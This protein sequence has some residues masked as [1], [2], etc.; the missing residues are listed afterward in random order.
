MAAIDAEGNRRVVA[1]KGDEV[2]GWKNGQPYPMGAIR[3]PASGTPEYYDKL[4]MEK[5]EK[6]ATD[7]GI[8]HERVARGM[9]GGA[10]GV[11]Y[12]G[13]S[14]I[15]TKAATPEQVILHEIGHQLDERYNLQNSFVNHPDTKVELRKLADLRFEGQQASQ[16]YQRYVRKGSEKMAV[17]FEAYLHAP[18]RFKEV[19]PKTFAKFEEFLGSHE[20]TKPI[21]DIKPSMVIGG[22]KVGKEEREPDTFIDKNGKPWKIAQATTKEIEAQ[23]PIRY[24][25]NAPASVAVN[26]LAM[27]KARRAY[28][29]LEEF[30]NSPEFQESAHSLKSP[31]AIPKGWRATQL[32]QFRGYF[33][34]PHI[35][36]VLDMYA[37]RATH[38]PGVL[39]QVGRFLRASIFFNPLIHVP[40][41]LNHWAVEKGVSGF[42]NPFNY[43][44]MTRAGMKAINAV[45]HQNKDFLEAL[46][47]GAPLQSQQFETKQF[48]DLFYKKMQE[49]LGD[50]E[51]S[52]TKELA[53]A[54][55][56]SPVNLVKAIYNF[57]GKVTWYTNDIAF[58]QSTYEKQERGM[59]LKDALVETGKHIPEYRYMTRIFDSSKLGS[60]MSNP[61]IT[62]FGAYHYGA[63]KSYGQMLKSL[64]GFNWEDAGT[65]NEKG[66][67]TN[68]AGRT[69]HEEKL[70]GLD[71]LAMV[72]LVTFVL[73]PML[74]E[75]WKMFT[76]DKR[77][78]MRRAG[79]STFIYNMLMLA[80]GEKT[81]T[82][83]AES[84]ATPAVPIKLAGELAFNRDLRTGQRIFD[85]HAKPKDLTEQVG[86]RLAASVAPVDQ[87]LQVAEGRMDWKKLMYSMV[88]V[89]FPLHGAQKIAAQ[90][91]AENLA[92]QPPRSE[93]EIAHAVRRSR[94]LHDAW[95]G[96]RSGFNKL[97]HSPDYTEKEK[98]KMRKDVLQ[99]PLVYAVRGMPYKDALKVYKVATPEEK[100]L[101]RPLMSKKL[102]NLI[103]AGKDIPEGGNLF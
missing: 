20:E 81:P 19:A 75:L 36:E 4:V 56:M 28:E 69:E 25:H 90:I 24:Y 50:P 43:P 33:F 12:T 29:F 35:A 55:G 40:N 103:K 96:D 57:S 37:K 52:K 72:G 13:Q 9:P 70:H 60:L 39:E 2:T 78:Q 38:D 84:I 77:A 34:E 22:R 53:T 82:E 6:L 59:S 73:Y 94:A 10:L 1:I 15:K 23:T 86:R 62:M 66:E 8:S 68:T 3:P 42:A 16:Y 51:S 11:S 87:G 102:D 45:I 18:E 98:A 54:L 91:N 89:S 31:G 67:P 83:V 74:D 99:P 93:A 27:D 26:Y 47:A 58:L 48:A 92:S 64:T 44:R 63:L 100:N 32:P 65:K 71:T 7:L 21:L 17:M 85:P 88:G 79:A 95:A 97:M 30:K 80:K 5:L 76:G 46:D 49:E 61:N 14:R 101:L 41:L